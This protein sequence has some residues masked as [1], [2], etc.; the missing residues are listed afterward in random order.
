M[1]TTNQ[2]LLAQA[3]R[4]CSK[5]GVELDCESHVVGTG[6][7]VRLTGRALEGGPGQPAL[8][9]GV[10]ADVSGRKQAEADRVDLLRRMAGAQEEERRRIARELHDQVGQTVT[11]LSLGLKTLEAA[12]AGPNTDPAVQERLAWLRSLAAGIG[13]DI[14]RAASDLRPAALDDFGLPSALK[15]LSA[16][17]TERHGVAV[18]TQIVGIVDRLP[19]EIETVVYRVAQEALTNTVRHA[20]AGVASVLLEQRAG[21]LRLIV[22]DD[23]VGFDPASGSEDKHPRLGLSGIRERLRLVNGS[24]ELETAPGAGT[25]LFVQIPLAQATPA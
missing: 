17:I 9:H 22:E 21:G 19:S 2:S 13:Q 25:T 14:H 23:G 4:R 3:V 20:G 18:D 11:G 10:V 6:R 8:L 7:W 16:A 15:A 5:E 12:L 1:E 24:L